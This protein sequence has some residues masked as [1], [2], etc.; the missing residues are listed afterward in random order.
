MTRPNQDLAD[1]ADVGVLFEFLRTLTNARGEPN[2]S[3]LVAAT[4]WLDQIKKIWQ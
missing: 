2:H 3:H 1:D 4:N